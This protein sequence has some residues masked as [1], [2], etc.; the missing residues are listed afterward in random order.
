MNKFDEEP[1]DYQTFVHSITGKPESPKL[2]DSKDN[3]AKEVLTLE[4][5]FLGSGSLE[6]C[7]HS[8]F[9]LD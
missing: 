3:K 4:K 5:I 1:Y 7:V 8:Q 2:I 6:S 9:Y